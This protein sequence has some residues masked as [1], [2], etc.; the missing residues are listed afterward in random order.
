MQKLIESESI[1]PLPPLSN[2]SNITP[3]E[4]A[5]VEEVELMLYNR[6]IT[7]RNRRMTK[8]IDALLKRQR[9]DVVY[10]AIGVGT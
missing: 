10:I 5:V 6:L 4:V 9:R 7:R 8:A 3:E 1:L 2:I